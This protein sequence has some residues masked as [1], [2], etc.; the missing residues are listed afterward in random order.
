MVDGPRVRDGVHNPSLW[1]SPTRTKVL[2]KS[3]LSVRYKGRKDDTVFRGRERNDFITLEI[4]SKSCSH[5]SS[6]LLF[7]RLR[8]TAPLTEIDP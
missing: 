1:F 6:I 4:W 3:D 5:S 2:G 7:L 8:E